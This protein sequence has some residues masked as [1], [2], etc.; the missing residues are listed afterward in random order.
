MCN[1]K[2]KKFLILIFNLDG[3][4]CSSSGDVNKI[5]LKNILN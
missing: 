2:G 3:T 1:L 4:P 5:F